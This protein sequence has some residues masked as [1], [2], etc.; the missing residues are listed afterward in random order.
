MF[1]LLLAV[2]SIE[3]PWI[4][5]VYF[6]WYEWDYDRKLGN[7]LGGVYYTPLHG[8]YD[9]RTLRDN[10]RSLR[11]ACEWG[12]THF[13]MDY[14][15]R[16]WKGEGGEPRER[17]VLRAAEEL[18]RQGYDIW[19]SYYQDGWN[20]EVKEFSKNISERRDT[21]TMLENYVK[22]PVWP[23]LKGRP[24]QMVYKRN[25][26]PTPIIDHK[27]FRDW[28]RK[29][30]R[31]IRALNRDWGT[32]YRG[33]DEI[34]MDFSARG[35]LRAFS[36][37]FAYE[38]W[39]RE[40]GRLEELI[41]KEFGLKG[42]CASFDVHY[43]PFRGFGYADYT[44]VFGGP[45]S[46][47][48][49]FGRPEEMDVERFIQAQ[50][51]KRFGV[52]FFDHLK[53]VYHD[54]AIRIPGQG[55]PEEPCHFDRFWTGA[56]AR[57]AQGVLH[58][59]WNEWWEGSNVEPTMEFGK[60][61]GEKN[62]FYATLMKTCFQSIRNW[63]E[64]AKVGVLLNDWVFLSGRGKPDELYRAIQALR[65]L[66]VKFELVP[67]CDVT[68][69][70]L[71][72]FKVFIAPSCGAGFGYN[73]NWRHIRAIFLEWLEGQPGAV[74][75][76]T[77]DRGV[78]RALG[79]R[80]G[81]LRGER[82]PGGP[83]NLFLDFGAEGD[84]RFI[85][86][87]AS[88]REDWGK[89]PEGAFGAGTRLT[90]RWTPA[91][92][93]RTVLLV[94]L[95]PHRD[96]L[97]RI[98]GSAIWPNELDVLL[99]GERVTS[100]EVAKG[101]HL[102]EVLIPAEVVGGRRFGLLTLKYRKLH[103]PGR[104]DPKRFGA[105]SRV[106][107]LAVDWLQL[108]TEE[109]KAG[110]RRQ[111]FKFPSA[112][113]TF[114]APLYGPLAG[115]AV[116]ASVTTRESL[117]PPRR[118]KV[119]AEY[120]DGILAEVLLPFGRGRALYINGSIA[121]RPLRWWEA[122]LEAVGGVKVPKF[123]KGEN[124]IGAVL[125]AGLTEVVLCYRPLGVPKRGR[126][127]VRLSGSLP[128]A[129]V[130]RLARDGKQGFEGLPFEVEGEFVKFSDE[131]TYHAAYEVVRA[132]VR[133]AV[134]DIEVIPGGERRLT[135]G[136]RNISEGP[137]TVWLR[138][139]AVIPSISSEP[140]RVSLAPGERR[141]VPLTVRA[142]EDCDWGRKTVFI[143][144]DWGRGRALF[145]RPLL[146]RPVP[147][148]EFYG[149]A[150]SEGRGGDFA[151]LGILMK[152][153]K[154]VAP[155]TVRGGEIEVGGEAQRVKGI[156]PSAPYPV[157][158]SGLE[159]QRPTLVERPVRL[160]FEIWGRKFEVREKVLLPAWPKRVPKVEGALRPV[161]I[162]NPTDEPLVNWPCFVELSALEGEF[163]VRDCEG[164]PVPCEQLRE[165]KAPT[166]QPAEGLKA[167]GEE[168]RGLRFLATIPARSG[169]LYYLC[170]GRDPKLQTDLKVEA[171]G[172]GTGRGVVRV[173]NSRYI[174][175][176][177]EAK[178]GTVTHL[179]SKATGLDYGAG[180]FGVEYGEFGRYDPLQPR[181]TADKFI[182]ERKVR[183]V[184]RP[185]RLEVVRA[186]PV[187]VEV[188]VTWEDE[189]V[190]A[191]QFYKFYAYQPW[192]VVCSE[193]LPKG[194]TALEAQ[195]VVVLDAKF[196]VNRLRK[197]YPNFTGRVT[198]K[199]GP[200]F[201][202]RQGR[203][204]PDYVTLM[205][206]PDFEESIS[207]LPLFGPFPGPDEERQ[208][209]WPAE[210]PKPGRC[211]FARVE[212]ISTSGERAEMRA[213][214]L[215]HRGHQVVA[216]RLL[217]AMK[218]LHGGVATFG[219]V[220]RAFT[221]SRFE[222]E[223]K[224]EAGPPLPAGWFSPLWRHRAVLEVRSDREAREALAVADL[225]FGWALSGRE[226]DPSSL[227]AFE[228]DE[229][230]VPRREVPAGLRGPLPRRAVTLLL[231]DLRR[232]ERRIIHLYF[233]PKGGPKKPS[234]P[235]YPPPLASVFQDFEGLL[236]GW[237]LSTFGAENE[238]KVV[239]TRE[240]RS[241]GRALLLSVPGGRGYALI[242]SGLVRAE[243]NSTYRISFW[244]KTL[245]GG[246]VRQGQLLRW[247]GIRLRA[248]A[249]GLG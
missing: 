47:G 26:V 170:R 228:V 64:G 59:S 149:S 131:F 132:P 217:E 104:I 208:G 61:Y 82:E 150:L 91:F 223:K 236:Y 187:S 25:G 45:H 186:G 125:R 8:Y 113:L 155:P 112:R 240:A 153:T 35:P 33:F 196:K 210:R 21:Y 162:F 176:L 179:I 247:P 37:K 158:L 157:L 123:V 249:G 73:R 141:E 145:Y 85:V 27:A 181:V 189:N 178:G 209:F 133:L 138:L 107:N 221:P 163:H 154:F 134:P 109:F 164:R 67:E 52:V 71:R 122:V 83:M 81:P 224:A 202:W 220:V 18:R 84:E 225:D 4:G 51:A 103:I 232:G 166:S 50:L 146:V 147:E 43:G 118:G 126:V 121:D 231:R 86:E 13:F 44:R 34:E 200:H 101:L 239:E 95:S 219:P 72:R 129:E 100:F 245:E 191:R 14:W 139:G 174:V 117:A 203:W 77:S 160:S 204:V 248:G 7:W 136:V 111:R 15:G 137:V 40:W 135:L 233:D 105:E 244:A 124:V 159:A 99:D 235:L 241:G 229:G 10:L 161:F 69:G 49:I 234:P 36:I 68:A 93:D 130:L 182:R 115:R 62:L 175:T 192:F 53:H 242:S 169:A 199:E 207:L 116:D 76:V 17:T 114:K 184:E 19:V 206:P 12:F 213:V 48:G 151:L 2:S 60:R 57:Y 216:E 230:G 172:L 66:G 89:L 3:R 88:H 156:K 197:I 198:D 102:Y 65:A 243:P 106:C 237:A 98:H 90:I 22:S 148:F 24:F 167:E 75:I 110:D 28:L 214:V 97:L 94:P 6:Y 31:S 218:A 215:L 70:N 177:E 9:N 173:E 56:L 211:K 144:A 190:K 119:L 201:G 32:S 168:V 55:Y 195:E 58:L 39:R 87:G 1:A 38:L 74:L 30:Y 29:I 205:T 42:L 23:Y 80:V 143:E 127:E 5:A 183:Q 185:G 222:W 46:Y 140:V 180:T 120:D 194:P 165:A 152:P 16:P 246:R 63:N 108:S 96:H 238:A 188:A 142:R 171:T 128:V 54:W 41:R 79:L 227:K 20:F 212:F 92:G 193:V 11:T 226:L 78:R